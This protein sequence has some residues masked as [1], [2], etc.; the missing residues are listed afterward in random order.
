MSYTAV[1]TL[2]AL[3][4]RT[5]FRYSYCTVVAHRIL[6][7]CY[8]TEVLHRIP[9]QFL[10]CLI[11]LH[12]GALI[13]LKRSGTVIAPRYRTAFWHSPWTAVLHLIRVH[14]LPCGIAAHSGR[15]TALVLHC[16]SVLHCGCSALRPI[17]GAPRYRTAIHCT[18][19]LR[20]IPARLGA[21][22]PGRLGRRE[23]PRRGTQ[24]CRV[25]V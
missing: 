4:Y 9:V 13:S 7:Q 22:S 15:V 18:E 5:A 17:P 10:H 6:V 23:P 2:I 24:V 21:Q 20:S 8:C 19:V 16:G 14:S 25:D 11:V 1:A 3:R 12:S